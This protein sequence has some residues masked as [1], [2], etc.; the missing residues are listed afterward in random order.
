MTR[1]FW[2]CIGII[3]LLASLLAT[4]ASAAK[5]Q[6]SDAWLAEKVEDEADFIGF[7]NKKR[8]NFNEIMNGD[9]IEVI[10]ENKSFTV[11]KTN[12][13][14]KLY[15]LENISSET[16]SESELKM[17][18]K[19]RNIVLNFIDETSFIDEKDKESL[20]NY[21]K[22][23]KFV[24]SDLGDHY[25][26]IYDH[27][28]YVIVNTEH[29][30]RLNSWSKWSEWMVVHELIHAVNDFLAGDRWL[31][32]GTFVESMTDVLVASILQSE[33]EA[34]FSTYYHNHD[35]AYM[36]IRIYGVA[37]I[38]AFLYCDYSLISVPEEE[39]ELFIYA[40]NCVDDEESGEA[41][42]FIA[43]EVLLKWRD[44]KI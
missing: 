31:E 17:I 24:L 7:N 9:Q 36:Y 12:T 15:N 39:L 1:K 35:F 16:F 40:L 5:S 43:K 38:K 11:F 42:F 32:T 13:I 30:N 23:I 26:A 27:Q 8:E 44:E 19:N 2:A 6:S 3:I 29:K 34:S 25:D 10:F 4:P 21:I 20:K 37:G 28:G 22:S 18:D 33:L 41:A 14:A